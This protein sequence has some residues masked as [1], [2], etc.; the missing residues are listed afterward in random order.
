MKLNLFII[1]PSGCGKS[2]QAKLIADKYGLT[3]LS[4]GQLLRDEIAQKSKLGLQAQSFIEQGVWVPDDLIFD[5]LTPNL[6]KLNNDNFIVDGFPRVLNQG[7]IVEYYLKTN[8]KSF[9]LLIHLDVTF[10]EI[11]AR[12]A[13]MGAEFQDQGRTDNTPEAV[14]Q[15]QQSYLETVNPIKDYFRSLGKLFDVNGNRPIEPIFEDICKAIDSI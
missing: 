6:E 11:L 12:R 15:R 7:K 1:G 4:M 13:K 9:S 14:K 2:T 8:Q 3:H 5:V 10:E